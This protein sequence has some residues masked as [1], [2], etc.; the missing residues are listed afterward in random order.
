MEMAFDK[1]PVA[2]KLG[3]FGEPRSMY[4]QNNN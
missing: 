4:A 1:K 3:D 2:C